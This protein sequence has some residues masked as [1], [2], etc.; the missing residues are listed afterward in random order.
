VIGQSCGSPHLEEFGHKLG[1]EMSTRKEA[2]NGDNEYIKR[3][4]GPFLS[5][6]KNHRTALPTDSTDSS[7]AVH[8]LATS[9]CRI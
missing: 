6:C 2:I 5:C 3:W 4:I 8:R 1:S 9:P 7:P